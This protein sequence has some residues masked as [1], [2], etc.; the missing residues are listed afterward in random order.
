MLNRLGEK[1]F[2]LRTLASRIDDDLVECR[3][4]LTLIMFQFCMAL[5][6]QLPLSLLFNRQPNGTQ[7][8]RKRFLQGWCCRCRRWYDDV[9]DVYMYALMA[10]DNRLGESAT[11]RKQEAHDVLEA[12][13]VWAVSKHHEATQTGEANPQ[14]TERT[15]VCRRWQE[16]LSSL[17]SAAAFFL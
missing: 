1:I 8:A 10:T 15:L 14:P 7:N 3:T 5:E 12:H 4:V 11:Y 6:K 16:F 17:A 2:L 13:F 9:N